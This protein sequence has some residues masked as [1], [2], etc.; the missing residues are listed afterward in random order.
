[1]SGPGRALLVLLAAGA[2]WLAVLAGGMLLPRA[3]PAALVI[4]PHPQLLARLPDAR[5]L[6]AGRFSITI[7]GAPTGAIYRAGAVLVLPAGLPL[8]VAPPAGARAGGLGA[9]G[10]IVPPSPP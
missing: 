9:G 6:D 5:F 2:G 8:C 7:A 10:A 3:A 4:L 1:M